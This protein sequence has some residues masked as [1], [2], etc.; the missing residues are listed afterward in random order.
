MKIYIKYLFK[1]IVYLIILVTIILLINSFNNKT[2]FNY[3][4]SI[5]D[6]NK[7]YNNELFFNSS[8]AAFNIEGKCFYEEDVL[9]EEVIKDQLKPIEIDTTTTFWGYDFYVG[10]FKTIEE[11]IY[12]GETNYKNINDY[13]A[14]KYEISAET[15]G[16]EYRIEEICKSD[17]KGYV[18]I[19]ASL[20]KYIMQLNVNIESGL[21]HI[22]NIN[23]IIHD[24]EELN[25]FQ[26]FYISDIYLN[27][28]K[29]M[30]FNISK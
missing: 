26:V 11:A 9:I 24:D 20:E 8:H 23:K 27:N 1:L 22:E 29:Y 12:F 18:V 2:N 19:F 30:H 3:I 13:F 28:V 21:S 16:Y 5:K 10:Y 14:K 7:T 6:T 15:M 25:Y 4:L 17:V